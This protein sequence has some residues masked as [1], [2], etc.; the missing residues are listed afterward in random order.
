MATDTLSD[1]DTTTHAHDGVE[2][3]VHRSGEAQ[4]RCEAHRR[5]PVA[6]DEELRRVG[7]AVLHGQ[8]ELRRRRVGGADPVAGGDERHRQGVDDRLGLVEIGRAHV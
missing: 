5:R 4:V 6:G 7:R 1:F 8:H 3:T 2:T